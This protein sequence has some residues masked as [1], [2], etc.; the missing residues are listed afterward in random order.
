MYAIRSYYGI[1]GEPTRA[2]LEQ[3]RDVLLF[4]EGYSFSMLNAGGMSYNFV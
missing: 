4:K 2:E 3:L 1:H